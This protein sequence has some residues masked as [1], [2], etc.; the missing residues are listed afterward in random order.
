MPEITTAAEFLEVGKVV[1]T[2]DWSKAQ[3]FPVL[4]CRDRS[5]CLSLRSEPAWTGPTA[6]VSSLILD[7]R[8]LG[9]QT[10]QRWSDRNSLPSWW[11]EKGADDD[12]PLRRRGR[13]ARHEEQWP[14]RQ[15]VELDVFRCGQG[16]GATGIRFVPSGGPAAP[17][18]AEL[19]LQPAA[20]GATNPTL[21]LCLWPMTPCGWAQSRLLFYFFYFFSPLLALALSCGSRSD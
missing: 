11:F 3:H 9:G 13:Y 8:P 12:A 19:R 5:A 7:C 15:R 20:C 1:S 17:R 18:L 10:R 4:I 21:L 2:S 16:G 6:L 14:I